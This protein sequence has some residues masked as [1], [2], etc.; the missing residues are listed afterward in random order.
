MTWAECQRSSY[1]L[2]HTHTHTHLQK[3]KKKHPQCREARLQYALILYFSR[4]YPEAEAEVASLLADISAAG[5]G[6]E[7]ERCTGPFNLNSCMFFK[8]DVEK[9]GVLHDKLRLLLQFA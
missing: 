4:A 2:T 9:I 7:A 6:W 3:E 1:L 8:E 5:G